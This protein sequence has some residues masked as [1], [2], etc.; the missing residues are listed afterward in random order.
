MSTTLCTGTIKNIARYMHECYSVFACFLDA[1]KA[2]DLV[3][4]STL[5]NRLIE[6]N[7]PTLLTRFLLSWHQKQ[8]MCVR[9]SNSLSNNFPTSNGVRQG[10]VL[11]PI[12]LTLYIDDLLGDLR[13][14]G[15]GCFWDSFFAG[16]LGY[17]DDITL[18]PPPPPPPPSPAALRLM[19]RCC[20]DLAFCRGLRFNPVKTQL[21]CFS[22]PCRLPVQVVS[23]SVVNGCHFVIL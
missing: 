10:G 11:S 7:F 18:L 23:I 22:G 15:V 13:D 20:E 1:S 2:F 19:L 14:F 21:I 17:A 8:R 6:R 5:F 16:A 3:N 9:W 12:L 4:H